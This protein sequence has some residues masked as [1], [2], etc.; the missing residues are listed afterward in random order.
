[1]IVTKNRLVRADA[2]LVTSAFVISGCGSS[3]KSDGTS[4]KGGPSASG[5]FVMPSVDVLDVATGAKVAFGKLSPS[6][7]P[8]LLW[9][10]APH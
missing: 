6:K 4:A 2:V 7:K 5:V 9:F 8:L 1:M 10:W 3:T